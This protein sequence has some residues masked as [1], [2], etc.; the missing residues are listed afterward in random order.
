MEPT[1]RQK[2]KSCHD[3]NFV[4]T[5]RTKGCRQYIPRKHQ[6][7]QLWHH[8]ITRMLQDFSESLNTLWH[9]SVQSFVSHTNAPIW[10]NCTDIGNPTYDLVSHN[11][12]DTD[13]N[14]IVHV[15]VDMKWSL[16]TLQKVGPVLACINTGVRCLSIHYDVCC[17]SSFNQFIFWK[18]CAFV[19]FVSY[20]FMI[21]SILC[22]DYFS[23]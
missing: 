21:Q 19:W 13:Y 2:S 7:R 10:W 11:N 4:V 8:N 18:A 1:H 6:W 12:N 22:T 9:H 20:L 14:V 5:G 15:D 3:S 23:H 17:M 16:L